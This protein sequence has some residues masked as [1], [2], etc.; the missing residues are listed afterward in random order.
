MTTAS[1][2]PAGVA[3]MFNIGCALGGKTLRVREVI[4]GVLVATALAAGVVG[5]SAAPANAAAAEHCRVDRQYLDRMEF[6]WN[7][8]QGLEHNGG[9]NAAISNAYYQYMVA[10]DAY[11]AEAGGGC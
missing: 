3:E 5:S 10:L 6:W 1:P 2:I 4:R 8:A 7:E 9:S 11:D